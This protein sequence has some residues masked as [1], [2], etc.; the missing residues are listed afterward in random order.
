ML[1]F[2]YGSNMCTPRLRFRVPSA[3]P[4]G[5]AILAGYELRWHKRSNDGSGKCNAYETSTQTSRVI[6]VLFEISQKEKSNLDSAEGL[7]YGYSGKDVVVIVNGRPVQAFTYVAA[8]SH[9]NESLV[10]YTWYKYFVLAGAVEHKHPAEYVGVIEAIAAIVDPDPV[11]ER[12]E[13]LKVLR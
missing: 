12:T 9:I 2:A 10:P 1:Y 6:G 13:R 11:R 7:G 8:P 5:L 4:T 3:I